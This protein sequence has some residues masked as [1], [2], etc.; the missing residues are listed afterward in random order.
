MNVLILGYG[1][2][3]HA[4]AHLLG[5]RHQLS[6]WDPFYPEPL[7]D[8]SLEETAARADAI[9]FCTPTAPLFDLAT[10]ISPQLSHTCLC[11]SMAKALDKERRTAPQA[12]LQ[13]LPE[14]ANLAMMYGPMI[15]EEILA[16]RPAF[17]TLSANND[18]AIGAGLALF[19]R[20]T[21]VLT[22]HTD[23]PGAALC[24]V[25]KNVYAMLFGMADELKL[26]DNVRGYLA[27]ATLKEMAD[28]MANMGGNPA[29]PYTLA[30]LGDLITTATS[31]DSHHHE[32]GRM[33]ARGERDNLTGEGV[34]TLI[35]LEQ[36]NILDLGQC[37]FI[38]LAR[39]IILHGA[40]ARSELADIM[41]NP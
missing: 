5:A 28:I 14:N 39:R 4:M 27:V 13:G 18:N 26:G 30:G 22:P 9:I 17:A 25:L 40:S 35:T 23:M 2:M 37:P 12:L 32:L 15:A 21:L 38:D 6:I 24:A 36:K 29:T 34:N 10:R 19:R 20:S 7:P 41:K 8:I 11:L 16:N 31:E 33:A 3:G 1:E